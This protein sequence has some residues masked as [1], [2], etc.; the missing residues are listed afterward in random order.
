MPRLWDETIAAHR[1]AVRDAILNNTWELV[2]QHGARSVTMGRIA[3]ASGI[4]R[5]TLY[6]YF[7]SVDDILL[8]WHQQHVEGHLAHLHMLRHQGQTA[9]ERLH[10]ILDAYAAICYH[11]GRHVEQ[12]VSLLHPPGGVAPAQQPLIDLFTALLRDAAD[13]GDVRTDIAPAELASYCLHA[14]G[15]CA[16][17]PDE[18]AAGKVV[19]VTMDGLRPPP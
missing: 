18:L 8:A 11:R 5:A 14:L 19:T 16:E 3:E 12:L 2:A 1:E 6:K 10:L 13:A 7:G 9:A 17:Q 15:A 4:G